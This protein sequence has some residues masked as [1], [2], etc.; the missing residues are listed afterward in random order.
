MRRF[1]A[2]A[3]ASWAASAFVIGLPSIA[4]ADKDVQLNLKCAG[5][6]VFA[7]KPAATQT[8]LSFDTTVPF[9]DGDFISL[10]NPE[11][12]KVERLLYDWE[13]L[14]GSFQIGRESPETIVWTRATS[15]QGGFIGEVI[16]GDGEILSLTIQSAPTGSAERP[17]MLMGAAA[18]SVYRGNCTEN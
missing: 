17:F 2:F 5:E 14:T 6:I 15:R 1:V 18:G 7:Q 13:A 10:S 12:G 8:K 3:L 16:G 9:G 4:L 11:T